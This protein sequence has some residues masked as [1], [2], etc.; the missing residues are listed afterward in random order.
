MASTHTYNKIPDSVDS[1]SGTS[2]DQES[3]ENDP[4]PQIEHRK[5]RFKLGSALLIFY[6]ILIGVAL[7]TIPTPLLRALSSIRWKGGYRVV[8]LVN[9]VEME[10]TKCGNSWEEAKQMGCHYDIMASRWYSSECFDGEV[11]EEMLSE[12]QA[13]FTWYADREHTQPVSTELALSGEFQKLYPLFDFHYVHCLYLWRKLH[14]SVLH[15][16]PLD[17]D[18]LAYG[19]TL[20]CTRMIMGWN[21]RN[22]TMD[23]TGASAGIPFCRR[24]PLG[25]LSQ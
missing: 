17:E 4:E 22:E 19:H 7:S 11:L 1:E 23:H 6:G 15:N 13:N 24:N 12:P 21:E 18:L 5:K 9:G 10:G 14:Y 8:H 3:S 25:F 16:Q 2:L 20:H